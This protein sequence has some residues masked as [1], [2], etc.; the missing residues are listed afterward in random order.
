[1][2]LNSKLNHID[3]GGVL[4]NSKP[5]NHIDLRRVLFKSQ[6]HNIDLHGG[7]YD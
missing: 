7:Q 3:M 2:L 6:L 1:M 5:N 4:L